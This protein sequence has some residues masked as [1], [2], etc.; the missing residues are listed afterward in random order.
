MLG[1]ASLLSSC[2]DMLDLKSE[3]YV[4]AED[5]KLDSA[6]DSLYSAM[7]ILTQMQKLGERYVLLGEL[8]G[9]IMDVTAEAPTSLREISEFNVTAGN[10]YGSR[11]DY[12]SVINNCNYALARMDTTI[13]EHLNR[14]M[15]PEYV[16]IKTMRAW[17][18][19]QMGLA[20]GRV[21]YVDKPLLSLDET[22]QSYPEV[23][24]DALVDM[25]VADL[26]RYAGEDVPD[27]GY[28]DDLDTRRFFIEP[29]LLLADLYLYRNEYQKAAQSYYD[30]IRKHNLLI[31]DY[32][33]TWASNQMVEPKTD[34]FLM[35]YDLETV[36][37]IPYASDVKRIHPN[38][39]NLTYNNRPTV[40]AA[41]WWGEAMAMATHFH[42]DSPT[43][44]AVSGMLEGDLRGRFLSPSTSAQ[45]PVSVG[46]LPASEVPGAMVITKYF[47]TAD[48]DANLV[49]PSNALAAGRYVRELPL[50]RNSHVYLRYAEALNRLGKPTM[51]FA[52]LKYG[53]SPD[54]MADPLKVD[55][56]ELEDEAA[57][58]NFSSHDYDGNIGTAQRGRGK[59][60]VLSQSTYVIPEFDSA[61]ELTE[62][63]ED[64]IVEEMA[65][66]T[67]FEGNRFFDLVRV[68]RHRGSTGYFAEKV[69]RRFAN[70]V[71]AKARLADRENWWLK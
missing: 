57:W 64:A 41:P 43:A 9:D 6:N 38:L 53:L 35:S 39:V 52:I 40:V 4:Y 12:Y 47:N 63:V 28:D 36:A 46:T 71:A 70:P 24:L 10:E 69:S 48:V 66:E 8:R 32:S 45:V 18:Y 5:N 33:N 23:E 56:A 30:Y 61:E 7:G 13:T 3:S 65:A 16:A 25:L 62:W 34:D 20:Y 1:F 58:T 51:A 11:R 54:V 22:E 29:R 31:S 14:V 37:E 49:N 42:I 59:G 44:T 17:T 60:I 68:S 26:E 50:Y 2:E 19:L 27:Y 21:R 15:V 67:Q 55:P